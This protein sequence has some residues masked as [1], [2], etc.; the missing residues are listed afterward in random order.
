MPK[1]RVYEV[2]DEVITR[3]WMYEVEALEEAAAMNLVREG[4]VSPIDCG[5][6]GEPF[7]AESGVAVQSHDADSNVGWDAALKQL[8]SSKRS[9]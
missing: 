3:K 4:E 1:F 8:E 9:R 5:T 2:Q 6:M 7:Y